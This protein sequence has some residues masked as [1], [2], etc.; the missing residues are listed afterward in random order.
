MEKEVRR[1]KLLQIADPRK[2]EL[3]HQLHL[4]TLHAFKP[5]RLRLLQKSDS[6]L[7][8]FVELLKSSLVVFKD[9]VLQAAETHRDEFGRVAAGLDLEGER[10][11]VVGD[12]AVEESLLGDVVVGGPLLALFQDGG[13][14]LQGADVDRYAWEED[15][16]SVMLFLV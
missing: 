5:L 13:E 12:F 2:F 14:V 10:L 1:G 4:L 16:L 7:N 3:A 8:A 9:F 11:H 15:F 6:L